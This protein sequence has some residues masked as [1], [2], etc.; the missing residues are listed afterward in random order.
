LVND[1]DFNQTPLPPLLLP[2]NSTPPPTG[3]SGNYTVVSV[4]GAATPTTMIVQTTANGPETTVRIGAGTIIRRRFDGS[5]SLL[6]INPGDRVYIVGSPQGGLLT[7][8]RIDDNSI[9]VAG[10]QINGTVRGLSHDLRQVAV[11]ITANEGARAAFAL[12]FT[13]LIDVTATTPVAF[14]GGKSGTVAQLRPGMHVTLY[15][16]SAIE[17][18]TIA[19][20][21]GV[22]QILPLNAAV[23]SEAA[24]AS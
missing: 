14:V 13:V 15:G 18:H 20:P 23:L 24:P 12:G 2:T 9:Q 1:F 10:S 19:G 4:G 3:G 22:T 21:R 7:A 11:T 6:E 16:L 17:S 8:T 5:S